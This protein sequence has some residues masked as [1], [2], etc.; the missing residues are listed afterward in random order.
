M[1][2]FTC[3]RL[4]K[5]GR[6]SLIA[7]IRSAFPDLHKIYWLSLR[8]EAMVIINDV[9]YTLGDYYSNTSNNNSDGDGGDNANT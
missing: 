8:A 2:I 6:D 4:D 7:N 5:D 9:S 1:P 3:G